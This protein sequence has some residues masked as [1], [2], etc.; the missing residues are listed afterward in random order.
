MPWYNGKFSKKPFITYRNREGKNVQFE[1]STY[2]ELKKSLK[3]H[4]KQTNYNDNEIHV[5][6]FKR[7]EW[8][9]WFEI[10]TSSGKQREGWM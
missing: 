6:R 4:F 10:W 7:G 9:E 8:G 5:T 3:E 1:F 2:R